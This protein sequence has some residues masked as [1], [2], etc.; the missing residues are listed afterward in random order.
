MGGGERERKVEGEG[1]S[2]DYQL[3][4]NC[5]PA[6]RKGLQEVRLVKQKCCSVFSSEI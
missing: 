6:S 2:N 3:V 1:G 4:S 5:K